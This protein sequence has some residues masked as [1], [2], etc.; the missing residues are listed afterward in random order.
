MRVTVEEPL[1]LTLFS[2]RRGARGQEG[3]NNSKFPTIGNEHQ[4]AT[5]LFTANRVSTVGL[6]SPIFGREPCSL[7][8]L[9]R[10]CAKML[11]ERCSP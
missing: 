8:G 7:M 10:L 9:L 3:T 4:P 1:T 5:A 2:P 6:G 11:G